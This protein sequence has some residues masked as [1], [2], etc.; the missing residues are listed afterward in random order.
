MHNS[1]NSLTAH[2]AP[3]LTSILGEAAIQ[4]LK[5]AGRASAKFIATVQRNLLASR[6]ASELMALDD[7]TLKDIGVYRSDIYAVAR[8]LKETAKTV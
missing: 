3:T 6:T 2:A 8:K 5:A 7:R 1:P 4:A